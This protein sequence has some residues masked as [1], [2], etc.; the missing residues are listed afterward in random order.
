MSGYIRPLTFRGVTVKNNLFF[1]PLAGYSDVAYRRI[2]RR[3]GAG[4]TFTEMVSAKGLVYEN[5]RTCALLAVAENEDVSAAQIFGGEPD[6]FRRVLEE[7][8]LDAFDI[9]DINMGCPVG[10]IIKNGEG[11]SLMN[12][13]KRAAQIVSTCRRYTDKVVSVKFRTGVR[14]QT[15]TE[16][17]KVIEGAGADF[18]TVHGRTAK[19]MYSGRADR[20]YIAKVVAAVKIPVI[21][22]GDVDGR[23]SAEDMFS[24]TGCAGVMIGRGALGNPAVFS[25]ILGTP[26]PFSPAEILREQFVEMRKIGDRYAVLNIRKHVP[27][28]LKGR[29]GAAALRSRINAC[30]SPE[31]VLALLDAFSAL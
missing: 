11:S 9:V 14:E 22:N 24:R 4:L 15:G 1:A 28:F 13:P 30:E 3:F 19:E 25:E 17:A 10:K 27:L 20:D 5:D 18:V 6:F 12:D 2:C 21:A 16:F 8:F 29:R 31:D 23:E 26:M 7:G